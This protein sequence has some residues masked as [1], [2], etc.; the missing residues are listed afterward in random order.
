MADLFK[1]LKWYLLASVLSS[2]YGVLIS[3]NYIT[4]TLTHT[5]VK[6]LDL[7][8]NMLIAVLYIVALVKTIISL[9]LMPNTINPADRLSVG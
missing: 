9:R 2:F 5:Q 4:E 7:G 8:V 3:A 6:Y 1:V